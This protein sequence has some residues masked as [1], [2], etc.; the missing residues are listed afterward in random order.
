MGKDVATNDPTLGNSIPERPPG[1]TNKQYQFCLEYV[2][3]L[4]GAQ[5]AIRAGYSPKSAS[6]IAAQNLAKAKVESYVAK[7]LAARAT[8]TATDAEYLLLRLRE[9]MDADLADLFDDRGNLRSIHDWPLI[10]RQGL[11]AGIEVSTV[12]GRGEDEEETTITK[13]KL[14]PRPKELVGRHTNVRAFRDTLDVNLTVRHEDVLEEAH[15]RAARRRR[16]LMDQL[17]EE[18]SHG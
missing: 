9:E 8:K 12:A 13:I 16:E 11:V 7:L 6:V 14:A 18:K 5:A 17:R 2:V 4:N 3:D 15:E 1:L 10:W